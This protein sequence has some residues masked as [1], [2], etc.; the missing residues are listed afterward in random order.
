VT[1]F[2]GNLPAV[3]DTGIARRTATFDAGAA[4]PDGGTP[5]REIRP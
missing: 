3:R 1:E 2:Y 4:P 5:A